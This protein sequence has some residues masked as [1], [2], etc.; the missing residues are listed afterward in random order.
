V[1][2]KSDL[3]VQQTHLSFILL[4]KSVKAQFI[5]RLI[6]LPLHYRYSKKDQSRK[7]RG[8]IKTFYFET[9]QAYKDV[10][11]FVDEIY[12]GLT[13]KEVQLE[14]SHELVSHPIKLFINYSPALA[15]YFNP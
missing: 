2:L 15:L 6:I 12:F 4:N 7:S 13:S 10:K 11:K 14:M 1:L 3:D 8:A 5:Y 9:F